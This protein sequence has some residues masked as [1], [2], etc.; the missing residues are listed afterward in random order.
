VEWLKIKSFM[1]SQIVV[2]GQFFQFFT[3]NSNIFKN[4]NPT[5][6]RTQRLIVNKLEKVQQLSVAGIGN[7]S[8]TS[9][10]IL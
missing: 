5:L 4:V 8:R 1:T 2:G 10:I 6:E 3:V 9:P 7:P